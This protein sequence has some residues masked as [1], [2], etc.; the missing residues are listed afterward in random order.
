MAFLLWFAVLGRMN[1]L[2]GKRL[3]FKPATGLPDKCPKREW[4]ASH[5]RKGYIGEHAWRESEELRRYG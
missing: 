4:C 2:L 1:E 5:L 3:P